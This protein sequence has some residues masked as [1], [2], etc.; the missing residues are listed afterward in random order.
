MKILIITLVHDSFLQFLD[1]AY[2]CGTD[3]TWHIYFQ[4]PTSKK[5]LDGMNPKLVQRIGS[6]ILLSEINDPTIVEIVNQ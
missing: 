1:L 2:A 3:T 5:Q 4:R 6:Y